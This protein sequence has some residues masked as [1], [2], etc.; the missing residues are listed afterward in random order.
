L[1]ALAVLSEEGVDPVVWSCCCGVA[2]SS[3]GGVAFFAFL[4]VAAV[5][6]PF[7]LLGLFFAGAGFLGARFLAVVD[8]AVGEGL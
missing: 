5:V 2:G 7:L 8:A 3:D 4:L 1:S 6:S